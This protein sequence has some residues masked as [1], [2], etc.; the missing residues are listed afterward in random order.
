MVCHL[1][2]LDKCPN[3]RPV[4]I[5][6][7]LCRLLG[8]RAHAC[9]QDEVEAAEDSK[10]TGASTDWEASLTEDPLDEEGGRLVGR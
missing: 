2:A 10:T 1:V 4:G 3:T 7:I 8:I 9:C 6:E 5:S